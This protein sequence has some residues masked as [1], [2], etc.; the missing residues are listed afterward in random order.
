MK[1]KIKNILQFLIIKKIATSKY[2]YNERI[3]LI[4]FSNSVKYF[5]V[6]S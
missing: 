1:D 5:W 3:T 2:L 6:Y 4:K